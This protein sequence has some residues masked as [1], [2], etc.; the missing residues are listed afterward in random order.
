[1]KQLTVAQLIAE[2]QKYRGDLPAFATVESSPDWPI[3]RVA[4]Y[5]NGVVVE[6]EKGKEN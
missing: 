5:Y 4:G 6:F 2:L 3:V 1:M